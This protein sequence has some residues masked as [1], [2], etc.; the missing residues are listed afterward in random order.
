MQLLNANN[1][2]NL[3]NQCSEHYYLT[4]AM[5]VVVLSVLVLTNHQTAQHEPH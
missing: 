1:D 4:L 3:I 2:P 5:N